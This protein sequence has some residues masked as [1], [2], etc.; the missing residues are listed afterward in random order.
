MSEDEGSKGL[1]PSLIG[2][3]SN[4]DLTKLIGGEAAASLGRL[5]GSRFDKRA[6]PIQ[7][8]VQAIRDEA[9]ARSLFS[10][11]VTEAAAERAKADPALV[12][13][14][15]NYLADRTFREQVNREGVARVTAQSLLEAPATSDA[16]Q[17]D[18]DW[19][20]R[21]E[22]LAS[23]AS[24]HELQ[25]LFGR[26]LAGEIR[27][28]A[29]FSLATLQFASV[30][31]QETALVIKK[32]CTLIVGG[33]YF[34]AGH[35]RGFLSAEELLLLEEIGFLT[36]AGSALSFYLPVSSERQV[37]IVMPP[38]AFR[39]KAMQIP[40]LEDGRLKVI[41]YKLTRVGREIASI[42]EYDFDPKLF[43]DALRSAGLTDIE[44]GRFFVEG[45]QGY[46]ADLTPI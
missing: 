4:L 29:R 39:A 41:A 16:R 7:A 12:D 34:V 23:R 27:Q 33:Q 28:R 6:A 36:M 14:A 22:E 40:F 5:I 9:E 38:R 37:E 20:N 19:M 43:G 17:P 42:V 3:L 11:A 18:Q 13:R 45:N 31:D 1:L 35:L 46:I 8:D 21:F 30:L 15:F 32:V 24:S 10:R 2:S 26:I 25:E 44:M